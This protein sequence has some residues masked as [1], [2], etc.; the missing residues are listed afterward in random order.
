MK[1][2]KLIKLMMFAKYQKNNK[3]KIDDI[4][5]QTLLQIRDKRKTNQKKKLNQKITS[6]KDLRQKSINKF[7]LNQN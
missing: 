3:N 5:I 1:K 7:S 2:K 4:L 6:L